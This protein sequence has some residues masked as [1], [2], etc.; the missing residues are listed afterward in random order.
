MVTFVPKLIAPVNCKSAMYLVSTETAS[1][2]GGAIEA[3]GYK[4][5]RDND[6][7]KYYYRGAAI[8]VEVL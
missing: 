5:R 4:F 3:A 2:W 1:D 6:L 8:T 7:F